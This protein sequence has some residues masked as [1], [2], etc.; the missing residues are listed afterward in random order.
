MRSGSR[1]YSDTHGCC[2]AP[3]TIRSDPSS[4]CIPP[5][6]QRHMRWNGAG[7]P[8][9]HPTPPA[10]SSSSLDSESAS[11]RPHAAAAPPAPRPSGTCSACPG[12]ASAPRCGSPGPGPSARPP[13]GAPAATLVP[14]GF[15]RLRRPAPTPRS[16]PALTPPCALPPSTLAK[17]S[18][19]CCAAPPARA[20]PTSRR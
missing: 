17:C 7:A 14:R 19:G 20:A 4:I 11:R 2:G 3:K 9:C 12:P 13:C 18:P 5:R 15:P 16:A 1:R 6:F 8:A 10:P